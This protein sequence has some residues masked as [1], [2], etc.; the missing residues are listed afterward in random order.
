MNRKEKTRKAQERAQRIA[1]AEAKRK[2]N[3]G[4]SITQEPPAEQPA[5]AE[6]KQAEAL[7]QHNA[8]NASKIS[9][10]TLGKIAQDIRYAE[11]ELE[12]QT[13][14]SVSARRYQTSMIALSEVVEPYL[15]KV[16]ES[17]KLDT[18]RMTLDKV[19]S[20]AFINCMVDNAFLALHRD[21]VTI[22]K[23]A[24]DKLVALVNATIKAKVELVNL[25]H[26]T[27]G[28]TSATQGYAYFTHSPLKNL[29]TDEEIDVAE[30]YLMST[31][32]DGKR[33][34]PYYGVRMTPSDNPKNTREIQFTR[35][36]PE[37]IIKVITE[38]KVE[39]ANS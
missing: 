24:K 35:P 29:F 17:G 38:K 26:S 9:A 39:Q 7:I 30:F 6:A 32:W 10:T 3:T 20:A 23:L 5:D 8:E 33:N 25:L 13:I 18:R 4:E 16:S 36:N 27:N 37:T 28:T 34:F 2:E 19:Q 1:E 15:N 22:D 21:K 31:G 14:L 11:T 12:K